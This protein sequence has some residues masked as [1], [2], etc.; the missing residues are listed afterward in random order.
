[1][2]CDQF[3]VELEQTMVKSPHASTLLECQHEVL[4]NMLSGKEEL[5]PIDV[6][7]FIIDAAWVV[8]STYHILL[9]CS[10]VITVFG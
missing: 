4:G 7:H 1:M 9:G 3:G 8:C 5:N 2:T 10:P 6:E